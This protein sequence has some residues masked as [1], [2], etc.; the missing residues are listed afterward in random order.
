MLFPGWYCAA[1]AMMQININRAYQLALGFRNWTIDSD[2]RE[3]AAVT[4][5]KAPRCING[6]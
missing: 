2:V 6:K 4:A 1:T 5:R 3:M